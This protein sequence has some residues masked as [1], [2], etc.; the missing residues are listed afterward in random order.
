MTELQTEYTE[1]K[2]KLNRHIF[3]VG[4]VNIHVSLIDTTNVCKIHRDIEDLNTPSTNAPIDIYRTYLPKLQIK[5]SFQLHMEHLS[6]LIICWVIK[7][8]FN[9]LKSF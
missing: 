4:D 3:M 7:K 8:S 9:K 5:H 2:L 6:R 1:Q